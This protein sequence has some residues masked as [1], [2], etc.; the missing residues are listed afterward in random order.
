MVMVKYEGIV[1]QSRWVVDENVGWN[2][3]GTIDGAYHEGSIDRYI[4]G[5]ERNAI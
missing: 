5:K 2:I 3:G 1:A 4:C